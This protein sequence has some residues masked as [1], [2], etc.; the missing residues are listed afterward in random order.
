MMMRW[1]QI[2]AEADALLL[3]LLQWCCLLDK[4]LQGQTGIFAFILRICQ[5]VQSYHDYRTL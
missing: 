4:Y 5:S 2:I 1:L 3:L